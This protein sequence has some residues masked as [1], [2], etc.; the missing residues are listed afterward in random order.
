MG[1][2]LGVV[3][4]ASLFYLVCIRYPNNACMRLLG[5]HM[6]TPVQPVVEDE[7]RQ[8]RHSILMLYTNRLAQSLRSGSRRG[9]G[10]SGKRDA[11]MGQE[12][13]RVARGSLRSRRSSTE[14]VVELD[15]PTQTAAHTAPQLCSYRVVT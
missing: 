1:T 11:E 15:E 9:S 4:L 10:Q 8:P 7:P 6:T 3:V 12:A 14:V 2:V 5:R 13:L